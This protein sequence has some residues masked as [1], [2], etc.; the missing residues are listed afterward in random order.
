MFKRKYRYTA[1]LFKGSESVG[2][3]W[4]VK[5]SSWPSIP[6]KG[7]IDIPAEVGF[8]I[9]DTFLSEIGCRDDF[10]ALRIATYDGCG[11][12]MNEWRLTEFPSKPEWR[13]IEWS[14]SSSDSI[15]AECIVAYLGHDF[16][17]HKEMPCLTK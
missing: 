16:I 6:S 10:D 1:E 12:P 14:E 11:E 3:P 9:C 17:V 7:A 8:T 2:G 4:F 13:L 15:D 5:L